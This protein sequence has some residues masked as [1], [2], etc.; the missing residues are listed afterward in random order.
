MKKSRLYT[1]ILVACLIGY[2]WL[3]YVLTQSDS[4]STSELNVCMI[5]N[6]LHI[7]CPAC[8][9]TRSVIALWNGNLTD[10]IFINPFGLIISFIL[11]VAPLWIIFDILRKKETFYHLYRKS[12]IV[13]R[14]KKYS[15]P[16]I[17]LV[18]GNWIWNIY[19]H[20]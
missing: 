17:V 1:L 4:A 2:T 7:P 13:L 16:L 19:K 9:S 15:I 18:I 10:S 8:G 6:V 12:E 20:L 11:L 14:N 3:G 5:K